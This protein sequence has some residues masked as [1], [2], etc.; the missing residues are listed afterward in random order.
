MSLLRRLH[1]RLMQG[2]LFSRPMPGPDLP[3][4]LAAQAARSPAAWLA[5][6]KEAGSAV[7]VVE[8]VA[9]GPAVAI[10]GRIR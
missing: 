4:W 1:C 10:A 7:P 5:D 2:F 8:V 9:G 6:A 3:V